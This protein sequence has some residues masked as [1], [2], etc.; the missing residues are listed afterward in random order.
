MKTKRFFQL[1]PVFWF[2][3]SFPLLFLFLAIYVFPETINTY[4]ID[5]NFSNFGEVLVFVGG[6]IVCIYGFILMEH[7][8]FTFRDETISMTDD[9][10][11]KN[12]KVQFKTVVRYDDIT[13]ISLVLSTNNSQNKRIRS[14]EMQSSLTKVYLQLTT[15]SG[16]N[17]WMYIKYF[18]KRQ[19]L[20]IIRELLRRME[21]VGNHSVTRT[22]EDIVKENEAQRYIW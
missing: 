18:T 15:R 8:H 4:L 6:I 12:R 17:E 2:G 19:K 22:P 1:P 16:K 5:P 13:D 3:L 20:K 21:K 11:S 14:A 7:L 9:W 10:F